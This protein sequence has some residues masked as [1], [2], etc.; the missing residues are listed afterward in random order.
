MPR[1]FI[2]MLDSFGVGAGK[3]AEKFGDVGADTFRHIAEYCAAGKADK[4]G[5]RHGPLHIPHLLRLGL[6]GVAEASTG[7][8]IKCLASGHPI[9]GIYGC[10]EEISYG[11][12]TPS[13]HWEMAG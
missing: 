12:D 13:G 4:A 1:V 2:I 6:N 10:A 11:K 7:N 3:D 9:Q 5:L 8:P